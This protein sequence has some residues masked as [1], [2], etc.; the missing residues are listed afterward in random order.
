MPMKKYPVEQYRGYNISIIVGISP[1]MF[2]AEK[3]DPSKGITITDDSL[4]AVRAQID[5]TL[6]LAVNLRINTWD[7]PVVNQT[8]QNP[9]VRIKCGCEHNPNGLAII[10]ESPYDLDVVITVAEGLRLRES[11]RY[12]RRRHGRGVIC[13]LRRIGQSR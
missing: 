5:K 12:R 6:S 1:T 2:T 13:A 11:K 7:G 4:D 10:V 3:S 9:K 8:F